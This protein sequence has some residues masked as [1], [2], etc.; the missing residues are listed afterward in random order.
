MSTETATALAE[1]AARS[2]IVK[3]NATSGVIV[4]EFAA[5]LS[6]GEGRTVDVRIVPYGERISHNDGLGGVARGVDYTE[7]WL[8]GAFAHQVNAAFRVHAN[9]EHEQGIN[10][11]VGH[12]IALREG[13][14]GFHGSFVLLETPAGETALQLI[15]GGALDGVSMEAQP[16]KN[17]RSRDGVIQRVKANLRA[18]A[19]TRFGAYKGARVLAIREEEQQGVTFDEVLLPVEMDAGLVERLRGQGFALPDRYQAHPD[20]TDT[21]DESGTSGSGTR[22]DGDNPDL[23]G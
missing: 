6:A 21:P 4:R 10:G 22:Q 13:A 3:S 7:E 19:F 15:K 23:E 9:V 11:K 17:I 18:V 14:D 5:Q 20:E 1:D 12:A 2:E 8:P 16:V